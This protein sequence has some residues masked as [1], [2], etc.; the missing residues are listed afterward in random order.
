MKPNPVCKVSRFPKIYLSKELN[1]RLKT[2]RAYYEK[3]QIS[4]V[5]HLKVKKSKSLIKIHS[6]HKIKFSFRTDSAKNI[7]YTKNIDKSLISASNRSI[8]NLEKRFF[9]K[10]S[11]K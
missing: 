6:P 11:S 2:I 9:V 1:S 4:S 10:K 8:S 3:L 7:S 5:T